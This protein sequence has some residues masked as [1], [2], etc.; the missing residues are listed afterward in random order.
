MLG[1]AAIFY[2][3]FSL[4]GF[5]WRHFWPALVI[6]TIYEACGG[7]AKNLSDSTMNGILLVSVGL[8]WAAR[9]ARERFP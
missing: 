2:G 1:W 9:K 3:L 8:A 6:V 5:L 4:I 7:K